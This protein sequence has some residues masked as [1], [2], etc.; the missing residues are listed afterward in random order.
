M[1]KIKRKY[2]SPWASRHCAVHAWVH[3]SK[4][5]SADLAL[6]VKL[7]AS[8]TRNTAGTGFLI[9]EKGS[10]YSRGLVDA[11][12]WARLVGVRIVGGLQLPEFKTFWRLPKYGRL[13]GS[14]DGDKRA[15]ALGPTLSAWC[16]AHRRGRYVVFTEGHVLAV[17]NGRAWGYHQTRSRV[18]MFYQVE[19]L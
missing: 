6:A 13:F 7:A 18:Q 3:V 8:T 5:P 17:V 16:R 15:V 2:P 4:K 11:R 12:V 9:D 14:D 10:A 19:V 1:V